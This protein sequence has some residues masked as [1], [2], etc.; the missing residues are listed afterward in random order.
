MALP[1]TGVR[2]LDLS[3]V[4]AGPLGTYQLAMLGAEVIKVERPGTGDLSRKMGADPARGK[5]LMGTSFFSSNAGKRSITLDL[6]AEQGKAI[7]RKLVADADVVF[8]NF[9]PGV[10]TRLGLGYEDLKKI[11]PDLIYCAVS[12]FGQ[13]GPLS[14]RPAYDQIIQGFSGLMS[15]TG[16]P[17]SGPVR[18]GY[19]ACDAMGAVTA[20]FAVASALYRKKDTGEGAFLDVAM[21]DSTLA[22]MAS[23]VISNYLNADHVPVPMGNENHSASPSGTY[24]TSDG[25]INLVT[26]EQKQFM[27]LC[28]VIGRPDLKTHPVWS[29]RDERIRL[30]DEMRAIVAPIIEQRTSAEWE[31]AFTAAGVPVGQIYSVPDILEH[32]H[33]KARNLIKT[34]D[35]VPGT[36]SG[37]SVTRLG[38]RIAGDDPDVATP[39]PQ[40]GQDNAD[41]LR[42]LGYSDADIEGLRADGVI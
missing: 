12:G 34:F 20:A 8:E 17:E 11:K 27:A 24:T 14:H 1:L 4:I 22:T 42:S 28:D 35:D 25:L 36:D 33:I 5:K 18:A 29:D 7:F 9:R 13:E 26:N 16:T 37:A 2:I 38:F 10:M 40:L 6:K 23:W 31:E 3:N 15:L 39:P 30:R 32:P 41:I 21:L 19:V